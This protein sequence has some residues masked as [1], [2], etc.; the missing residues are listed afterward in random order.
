MMSY[1]LDDKHSFNMSL[2]PQS[3][4]DRQPDH[5]DVNRRTAQ[6]TTSV[7]EN[8]TCVKYLLLTFYT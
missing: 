6:A 5:D 7:S 2:K 4:V 1:R 8:T 3:Y